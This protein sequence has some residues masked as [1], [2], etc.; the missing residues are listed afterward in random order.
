[1]TNVWTPGGSAARGDASAAAASE[2]SDWVDSDAPQ[3]VSATVSRIEAARSIVSKAVV[4][5][6]GRTVSRLRCGRATPAHRWPFSG[7][8][9]AS[10][11]G[12]MSVRRTTLALL[13]TTCLGCA[14]HKAPEPVGDRSAPRVGWVI[15]QG[16]SDNPD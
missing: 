14:A 12:A 11:I 3:A 15:M 13:V 7:K 10:V 2:D 4:Y 1:M 5:S 6:A 8:L 16:S 9:H